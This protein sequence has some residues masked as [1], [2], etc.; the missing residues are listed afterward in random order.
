MRLSAIS[1]GYCCCR[2]ASPTYG[3]VSS[4]SSS[5]Q[6]QPPHWMAGQSVPVRG[7]RG[8]SRDPH[9]CMYRVLAGP[10]FQ[11][12]VVFAASTFLPSD[13]IGHVRQMVSAGNFAPG[14]AGVPFYMDIICPVLAVVLLV[15][16]SRE[17]RL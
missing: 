10:R 13:A 12:A 5:R 11:A 3:R 14:N 8:R 6:P 15:V 7:R 16:A 2:L 1:R 4:T 9:D 17:H